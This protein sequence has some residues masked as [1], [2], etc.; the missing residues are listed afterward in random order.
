MRELESAQPS[1]GW[2]LFSF[3]ES[4]PKD[5]AKRRRQDLKEWHCAVV[6]IRAGAKLPAEAVDP[7]HRV[8]RED[9]NH[10]AA[11]RRRH[12]AEAALISVPVR[13]AERR[14]RQT[15]GTRKGVRETPPAHGS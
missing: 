8:H 14:G 9:R 7:R 4:L 11:T 5:Q 15:R 13:N 10:V 6:W 2:A 12:D 3:S 1:H